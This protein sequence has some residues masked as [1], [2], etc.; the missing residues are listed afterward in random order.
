MA[1]GRWSAL[2]SVRRY[3]KPVAVQKLFNALRY[4]LWAAD[5]LEDAVSGRI[6]PL[7]PQ[8]LGGPR[9]L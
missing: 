6:Q 5:H 9:P 3:A 1:R 7:P 4:A 8:S 2:S